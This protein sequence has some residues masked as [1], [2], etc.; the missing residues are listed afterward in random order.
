M[1]TRIKTTPDPFEP[2]K[3]SQGIVA[4]DFV[5]LSGQAAIDKQGELVG[6][7]DFNAQATQVMANIAELLGEVG[8]S[9]DHIVKV[10]IYL[11]D[12]ANFEAIMALR[13]QYFTRPWPADTIV[14][15]K[16]L[17][18]PEL[19]LEIDATAYLKAPRADA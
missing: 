14:E 9:L 10:T 3:I 6:V 19:M 17:A 7:G 13:E 5:F 15:V 11:T 8:L 4:G 16:S 2:Y 1:S 12:M 18:L